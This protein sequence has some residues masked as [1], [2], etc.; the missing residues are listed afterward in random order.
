MTCCN[1]CGHTEFVG[2]PNEAKIRCKKCN[3]YPR[4]RIIGLFLENIIINEETLVL[5]LAPEQGLYDYLKM[6]V[7]KDNYHCRDFAPERYGFVDN[8]SKI[9]LCDLSENDIPT[10]NYDLI[11]HSHVLE[12]T[13][14]NIAYSLYHLH[15]G[16]KQSGVQLC[17]IPFMYGEWDECFT[18][19]DVSERRRRFGQHDHVRRIGRANIEKT[20]NKIITIPEKYSLLD[21]FDEAK[22]LKFNIPKVDWFGLTISTVLTL[23]KGDY[24]LM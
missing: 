3:S 18:D 17:C 8:I 11:I 24:K 16:L 9:D 12:H 15:R 1:L 4:T 13:P 20:L 21:S 6:R 5:H 14:C 22:L 19:I 23:S 7:A 2:V 10:D